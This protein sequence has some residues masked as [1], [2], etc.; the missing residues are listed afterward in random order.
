[1]QR[2]GDEREVDKEDDGIWEEKKEKRILAENRQVNKH[3]IGCT[4]Q[5]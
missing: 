4:V 2:D 5:Q 3:G 1:M